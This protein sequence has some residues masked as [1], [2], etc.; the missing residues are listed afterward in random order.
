[1]GIKHIG[2]FVAYLILAVNIFFI[3]LLLL[4]AYSPHIKPVA[5]PVESC[6][7]LT[8][9]IF[10]VINICFFIFWLIIQ[11]YKFA[12]FPLVAFLLCY[13]QIRTYFPLNFHTSKLPENSFKVLSYA[14]I[15][16]YASSNPP[17]EIKLFNIAFTEFIGTAIQSPLLM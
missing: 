17:V 5:H 15:P 11:K 6:F 12:L 10:L 4:T 1:M 3:S 8:F 7:G 13:S 2:K 9:P 14:K 16:K